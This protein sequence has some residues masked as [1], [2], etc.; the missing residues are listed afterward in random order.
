MFIDFNI[1]ASFNVS[2]LLVGSSS[3]NISASLR[4]ALAIPILCFS[5]DEKFEPSSPAF[6]S[7]P[8]GSV[9]INS[10]ID[11]FLQASITS[12]LDANLFPI[13]MLFSIVSLNKNVSCVTS[14]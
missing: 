10:C 12:S 13:L 5:P 8:F 11:A 1:S 9:F 3:I 6:V 7:Y 4:K 2:R 14:D